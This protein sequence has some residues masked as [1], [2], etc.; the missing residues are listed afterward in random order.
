MYNNLSLNNNLHN[1]Y[2]GPLNDE[3]R[4][5]V[6]SQ[7]NNIPGFFFFNF[8]I[9]NIYV[10]HIFEWYGLYVAPACGNEPPTPITWC[11]LRMIK[12]TAVECVK[13]CAGERLINDRQ[14]C[15]PVSLSIVR[16]CLFC[17]RVAAA[18]YIMYC[19]HTCILY[20][21]THVTRKKI[22]FR[23]A[24]GVTLH[25]KGSG[26]TLRQCDMCII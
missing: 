24:T 23:P 2:S 18:V 6:K 4:S 15:V 7:Q 13:Y 22:E 3:V 12:P 5:T 20:T 16:K 17:D 14:R 8:I 19:G 25:L 21:R 1:Y 9:N 26:V 10:C 11:A